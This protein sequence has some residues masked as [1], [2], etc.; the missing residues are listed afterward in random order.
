MVW[1]YSQTVLEFDVKAQS[2]A[3]GKN[4][5]KLGEL[6]FLSPL[7]KGKGYGNI[8]ASTD[9]YLVHTKP[10]W[11]ELIIDTSRKKR[12]CSCTSFLDNQG[13][14]KFTWMV[15]APKE[16]KDCV[17]DTVGKK[18]PSIMLYKMIKATEVQPKAQFSTTHFENSTLQ[19][20]SQKLYL[21]TNLKTSF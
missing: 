1:K 20:H 4:T 12:I 3:I 6:N 10:C 16:Q 18:S 7:A 2:H 13:E 8:M 5:D 19:R 11:V 9:Q 15:N 17:A 21:S 14:Q